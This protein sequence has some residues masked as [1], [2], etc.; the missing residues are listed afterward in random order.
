V[1]SLLQDVR[2]GVRMLLRSPGLTLVAVLSLALGIGAN[3][4]IFSLLDA[5]MLKSLP[6]WDPGRLLLFGYG[7]WAIATRSAKR[8]SAKSQGAFRQTIGFWSY[9]IRRLDSLKPDC[10]SALQRK[11]R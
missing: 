6:V 9:C 8:C 11:W 5:V 1:K 7:R 10:V 3:T 4:A 2:Y